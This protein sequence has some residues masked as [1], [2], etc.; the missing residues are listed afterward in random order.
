EILLQVQ[1]QLL[2]ADDRTEAE[3]RMLHRFLL[4]LKE[5]QEQTFYNKKISLGVVRS[6]LISSLEERFSPLA[7]ES[8]FLTGGIT[9]CSMLPMRAIPFKVIYLL[10]LND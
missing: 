10:G 3:E 7:S 5:L 6:Y 1:N 4:S 2:I 9:F 8:G